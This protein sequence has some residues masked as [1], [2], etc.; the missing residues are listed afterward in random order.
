M[1]YVRDIVV[2][3]CEKQDRSDVV[4]AITAALLQL[5]ELDIVTEINNS[6]VANGHIATGAKIAGGSNLAASQ[7]MFAVPPALCA[8]RLSC[9]HRYTCACSQQLQDNSLI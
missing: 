8:A 6:L 4:A 9:G 2:Y 7:V 5:K 1:E 3:L